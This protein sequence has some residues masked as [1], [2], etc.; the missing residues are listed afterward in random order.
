[1]SERRLYVGRPLSHG[2]LPLSIAAGASVSLSQRPALPYRAERL[3]LR[4]DACGLAVRS[5]LVGGS[6][7]SMPRELPSHWKEKQMLLQ[8][9]P[10]GVWWRFRPVVITPPDYALIELTNYSGKNVV[11]QDL[12]WWGRAVGRD[13]ES[14]R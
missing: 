12:T 1:M 5:A 13:D 7:L 8:V 11:L 6:P 10:E 9:D 3:S 4:A 14:A 2:D